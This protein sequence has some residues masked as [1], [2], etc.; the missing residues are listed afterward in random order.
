MAG[1]DPHRPEP[2]EDRV[3]FESLVADLIS[4]FVNL[5][6]EL[7]DAEIE[8]TLRRLVEALDLDRSALFQAAEG[9]T[10]AFT[11][12]WAT[13][14]APS[15]PARVVTAEMFPWMLGQILTGQV[16][17]FAERDEV[18]N[19]ID[20]SSLAG[21]GTRSNVTVPLKVS[22]RLVGA[23][24]FATVRRSR[25]WPPEL[26]DRFCLIGNVFAG[27][28][29]RKQADV[30]LRRALDDNAQLRE[31]LIE[32]NSYL[33]QEV[34]TQQGPSDTTGQ[35]RAVEHLRQQIAQVAPT[36]TSVLLL[37]ET[38][39]GKELAATEI[40]ERSP[41]AKRSMVSVH[42]A[43]IPA[44]LIESELFG[45]EKGAYTGAQ[46]RQIGR[47]ELADGSTIFLDEVGELPPEMQVKLLRV[48]QEREIQRLGNPRPIK[49]DVR[50]IAA[51]NRDLEREVAEGRF[52]EDLF[53]RLNVFP[54]TVPPLRERTEDI[55]DLVR[56]F[57]H[58]LAKPLGKRFDAI[59]K[60]NMLALQQHAWP[61]NIRE[62]RNV[63]ERAVIISTPPRLVVELPRHKTSRGGRHTRLADVE[64][65]HLLSV[66]ERTHWRVRGAGGAAELVGLKPSTLEGRL[67]KLHIKRPR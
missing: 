46:A 38:G 28:V 34:R 18:P 22:G 41:R 9:G 15:M 64:R 24:S 58:E 63:V 59:S 37:G 35:S 62:L 13:P 30:E 23:L 4:H 57:V 55:P 17:S 14:G 8:T 25:S 66:L 32:E 2:L 7:I 19:P 54:I 12:I 3:R 45:A 11:H 51:T 31:R 43:A 61:G 52:R 10:L 20:R 6:A 21:I 16:V 47:F 56:T 50:V 1:D 44:T 48:L 49:I 26:I 29:A 5:D 65:D 36:A 42:C 60:D 39:T 27:A 67:A 40:H 33:Q 53:Y